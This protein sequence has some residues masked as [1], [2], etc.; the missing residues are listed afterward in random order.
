LDHTEVVFCLPVETGE[1]T[2][3]LA[4]VEVRPGGLADLGIAA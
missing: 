1:A 2:V 4:E 3:E